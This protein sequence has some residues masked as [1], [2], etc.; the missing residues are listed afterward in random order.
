MSE[1]DRKKW[2][3]ELSLK[4]FDL[5]EKYTEIGEIF[6]DIAR[7]RMRLHAQTLVGVPE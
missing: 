6:R 2:E 7:L 5:E 4:Y 3:T 1:E